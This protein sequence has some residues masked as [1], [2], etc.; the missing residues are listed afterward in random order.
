V[1][2]SSSCVE[3]VGSSQQFRVAGIEKK[4]IPESNCDFV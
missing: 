2:R 3:D 4:G 1:L